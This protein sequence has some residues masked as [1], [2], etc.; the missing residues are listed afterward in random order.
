MSA[1]YLIRIDDVCPTMNWV[2]WEEVEEILLKAEIKPLLAVVPDNQDEHLN[3]SPPREEFWNLVRSW[4]DRG[5]S[6]GLHGYQ[7]KYVTQ[8][9]GIVG[10]NNRSEFAGLPVESQASKLHMAIDIFRRE[11]IAPDFWVAP[12]H[13]FDATTIR[14]LQSI[15]LRRVSDGLFLFPNVDSDGTLWIPQQMWRFRPLPFGVWCVCLH[16]NDWNQ[17]EIRGFRRDVQKYRDKIISMQEAIARF[18]RRRRDWKD[19]ALAMALPRLLRTRLR[20]RSWFTQKQT[21]SP[22]IRSDS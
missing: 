7:H 14:L 5:W 12:A 22:S 10:I 8:D 9:A 4:H 19:R 11:G 1:R 18:G 13:S 3:V 20:L 15:G 21:A 17:G 6:I 16:I 2:V